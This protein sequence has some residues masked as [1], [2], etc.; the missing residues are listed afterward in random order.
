MSIGDIQIFNLGKQFHQAFNHRLLIDYPY[1]MANT[2]FGDEY[3]IR[4]VSSR[5][6]SHDPIDLRP[7]RIGQEYGAGI[8]ITDSPHAGYGPV[9]YRPG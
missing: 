9:L 3:R 1:D 7:G 2:I 8:G 4:A 6:L 5:L